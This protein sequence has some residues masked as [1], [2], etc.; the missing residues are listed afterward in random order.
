MTNSL[1]PQR[2]PAPDDPMPGEVELRAFYGKLPQKEPGPAL[3]AAVLRAAAEAV[4]AGDTRPGKTRAPRWLIGLGSAA[5]L[6]LA[7]GLA[8]QMRGMPPTDNVS[9][10]VTASADVA[11]KA[12]TTRASAARQMTHD[13]ATEQAAPSELSPPP[14]PAKQPPP[15]RMMQAARSGH[16]LKTM[17]DKPS[18]QAIQGYAAD[19][20]VVRSGAPV[21]HET[22]AARR[23]SSGARAASNRAMPSPRVSPQAKTA[24]S[25]P[26]PAAPGPPLPVEQMSAMSIPG[27]VP[28]QL[29]Q[30]RQLYALGR[31]QEARAK[32]LAFHKAHPHQELP[33]DLRARLQQ[34]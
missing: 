10:N 3:D 20:Q 15:K 19:S 7:A 16:V 6:V 17:T 31:D 23:P 27:D 18:P 4:S 26:A 8:W 14:E 9:P 34:P 28:A 5:T 22:E 24:K 29:Q 11:K 12:V 33:D 25:L 32:L 2:P 21:V 13:S 1:P 30:I